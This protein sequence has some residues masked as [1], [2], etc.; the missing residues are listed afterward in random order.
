MSLERALNRTIL[1]MRDHVRADTPTHVLLEALCGTEAVIASDSA[2]LISNSAQSAVVTTASLVV[3][4]G[5]AIYLDVPITPLRTPQPPLRVPELREGLVEFGRDVIP[6]R[7]AI[8]SQLPAHEVDL[9]II[10]GDSD[11]QGR[12]R[13]IVRLNAEPWTAIMQTN[14]KASRWPSVDWP[15]GGLGAGAFAAGEVFK[16]A[17][18]K[19]SAFAASPVFNETFAPSPNATFNF[20]PIDSPCPSEL[21]GIDMVSGGAICHAIL[22]ILARIIGV[23]AN[24]RVMDDDFTD[25]SNLNRYMLLRAS[26]LKL[27]KVHQLVKAGLGDFRLRAVPQRFDS[28]SAIGLRPL[29]PRVMVGVDDIPT[30]WAVQ[31]E[32][33]QW[34]CV[35]ATSHYSAMASFH[36]ADLPC[37]GCLHPRDDIQ[38][39]HIPTI[40][41]VSFWAGLLASTLLLRNVSAN[42]S[43]AEEQQTYFTPMRPDT[44]PWI[45]PVQPRKDC[46]VGCLRSSQR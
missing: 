16:A 30:R 39:G 24:A 36:A 15:L 4:S 46:P 12:A 25:D 32:N 7:T 6:G 21:G 27:A 19:I 45:G 17:M 31:R 22:F 28:T 8:R 41:F 11:W 37:A 35:G 1:L 42:H 26:E 2:N 29:A 43:S 13:R 20:A 14:D 23:S 33:P 44:V 10:L 34:L 38:D 3:R 40:A 9:A 18:R 5:G